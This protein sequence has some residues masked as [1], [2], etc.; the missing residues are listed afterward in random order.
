[1]TSSTDSTDLLEPAEAPSTP[2]VGDEA[3]HAAADFDS[4]LPAHEDEE[5][6]AKERT[7]SNAEVIGFLTR[8]WARRPR[9]FAAMTTFTLLATASDLAL[10]IAAGRLVDALGA[11]GADLGPASPETAAAAWR[12]LALFVALSAGAYLG[13]HL[14][15]Q[16]EIRFSSLNMRDLTADSFAQVQR[17]STDWHANT[18]AGATVRK[19]S[20]GMWAY[21]MVTATLFFGLIPTTVV[22]LGLPLY[23]LSV[24][25]IVGAYALTIVL[26]FMAVSV[27]ASVRYIKPANVISNARDSAIGAAL[28]DAIGSNAVVKS[29]GAEAREDRR[30]EG[31]MARWQTAAQRTWNRYITM[32]LVQSVVALLLSGGVIGL[33]T[34]LWVQGRATAG[35][36]TFAVSAFLLMAGYLRRFGEEVQQVQRGLD[37]LEDLSLFEQAAPSVADAPDAA[38]F[39]RGRGAIVFD[40]VRFSYENQARPLYEDFSLDIRPGERVAL[41]GPTGS[42]KS[43]FVKLVQRLYDV[44]DGRILIDGQDVRAVT[45]A[46]LRQA[47]ALVPQDPALFHRSIGANI[48]YAKPD[49][50]WAEVEDVARRARAY[51]FIMRLPGG[52]RTL[53]GERGVKLS[54]GERQRIAI[55]RALLA[56][57]PILI[58]DEATSSLDNETERL[59]Q[60]AMEALMAGRTTL[61]IAHRLSTVRDADRILVFDQGR[62]VEQGRHADL[63]ARP[64]GVYA[65]LHRASEMA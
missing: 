35:D 17:F 30:F 62:I 56:D 60:E 28:A 59:V 43:T 8:Q 51:D 1:M 50:S 58:L 54:G 64:D 4:E 18:F 34:N 55:A 19:I 57:A 48:A 47:V 20:R 22:L 6:G 10:P 46:S 21:D 38:E 36:V 3:V 31:V 45:Q 32:G 53:V 7:L 44:Q 14:L 16:C 13:R 24:W 63:A 33:V 65:R 37:E 2:G 26:V 39:A 27:V 40:S 42:G 49:A 5:D 12:A 52:F 15:A 23:M 11:T 61:V 41:V 9:L 25:P 29:F